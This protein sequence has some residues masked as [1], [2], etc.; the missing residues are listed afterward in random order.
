MSD[1]RS[2]RQESRRQ[3]SRRQE[4]RRAASA[5]GRRAVAAGLVIGA[6]ALIDPPAAARAGEGDQPALQAGLSATVPAT[7]DRA[8]PP[9]GPI[10]PPDGACAA[11]ERVARRYLT[12]PDDR[13]P[14]RVA[15]RREVQQV[16]DACR[17]GP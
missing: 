16:L 13:S 8:A 11:A 2:R 5:A 4:A 14:R 9:P 10:G 15:L 6:A 7:G 3:E 12:D 1:G 17:Q